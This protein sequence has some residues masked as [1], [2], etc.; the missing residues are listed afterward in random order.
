MTVTISSSPWSAGS[1]PVA[2]S[3]E[4]RAARVVRCGGVA[5]TAAFVATLL[6][7]RLHAGSALWLD[8]AQSVD[9]ARLP[10]AAMFE[11][12]RQDGAP[13]VYYL[14]LHGWID[15]VGTGAGAVRALSTVFSLAALPLVYVLG[16]RLGGRSAAWSCPVVLVASP[17]AVRYATE[18]R[19]YSLVI[20][21]V[22]AGAWA[23][24]RAAERPTPVRLAVVAAASGL[25]SLTH[26]WTLFLL[27]AVEAGLVVSSLRNGGR[28]GVR[29]LALA[30]P[31]GGLVFV[32][33]LPSFV[34]QVR[35]TGT[36]WSSAPTW[37]DLGLTATGWVGSGWWGVALGTV[38][39][40]LLGSSLVRRPGRVLVLAGVGALLAG[41][42]I[43]R[44]QGSGYVVRYS[45]PALTP[46][47]LAAGIGAARLRPVRRSV[48][49][50]LVSGL[51]VASLCSS[52]ML[53]RRT[54]AGDTAALIRSSAT[55][56]AVVVFCPDQLGPAVALLLPA[57]VATTTYPTGASASRVDWVDYAARNAAADPAAFAAE[58]A[59]TA[60][61]PV[62]LVRADG[63]LT[64]G[65]QCQ[66]LD[67]D[68]A[69]DL[70][71]RTVLQTAAG[72]GETEWLL[73]Y[74]GD[75]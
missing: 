66:A 62:F 18:C 5:L 29:R 30:V 56:G 8:E 39:T 20:L 63:Y 71:S 74:G 47:L 28:P 58:V 70:G 52:G 37:R 6:A 9:I 53:A 36:P 57:D 27:A 3:T 75:G 33:W 44:L 73:R 60:T 12:L 11:A 64:Y 35:H 49:L 22:L 68:L 43:S 14:L 41:L 45:A 4:G 24:L 54:Q 21:M 17:F 13:P 10:V 15:V 72:Q 31:A 55:A 69:A 1:A 61:G 23:L 51:A 59:Q 26:Y 46:L 65:T 25:L 38:V 7:L 48:A 32:P 50:A 16:R 40:A 2:E 19:M 34:D 67:R 42:V